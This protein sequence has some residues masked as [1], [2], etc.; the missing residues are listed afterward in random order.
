MPRVSRRQFIRY[1]LTA[2]GVGIAALGLG[3]LLLP[4]GSQG[5]P[6]SQSSTTKT[7][8]VSSY[9]DL[10]D[11]QDFL[12]W[13]SSV[14]GP[15]AGKTLNLTLEE[16]FTPLTLQ[17]I[18]GDFASATGINDLYS[19]KPYSLQLSDVSLMFNTK[20]PTYDAF[21]V[22][23]QNLGA[24]PKDSL[25]PIE[26]AETYP[27]LTYPN[28]DFSD[29]NQ[30]IWDYV[31]TYP[32]ALS[33]GPGGTTSSQVPVLPLDT[34]TMIHYYRTDIYD[35]LELSPPQTWDELFENV[36]VLQKAGI[37]PFAAASQAAP[38]IDIVYEFLNH[39][40]SFG[41]ELWNVDGNVITPNLNDDAVVAALENFVR[42]HDYSDSG[43]TTYSWED[44]FNSLA[45]GV[46]ASAVLWNDFS[47]WLDDPSRSVA[48]GNFGFQR[49]PAGPQGSFSTFGGAGV[50]VSKYSNNPEAAWLWLQ[51]A[52]AK[53]T[54]EAMALDTYHV[55]PTRDSVTSAP[56]VAS[57][58]E[59]LPL[60]VTNLTKEIV[61][62]G[63]LVALIGFP[64]W[65]DALQAL[66][67]NL[68]KAWNGGLSP[69]GALSAAQ[70]QI[71]SLGTLTF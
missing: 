44:V 27:N 12:T 42:F 24:F 70:S 34:P 59:T 31:G 15:Y 29:F 46:S 1:G 14:S 3:E 26:L 55:Y 21:G 50:G 39:V 67:S 6:S 68:N 54:Q 28:F 65:F 17:L 8:S 18:D 7:S 11:Y 37:T 13:L 5:G 69:A 53:G 4:K 43:S 25:S 32:P 36:Q 33:L 71:E 58:L 62:S 51:W 16:E 35:K 38:D 61:Q 2:A 52:T 47:T 60:G 63:G 64:D 49:V 9:S 41:G 22:D 10:P 40:A 19:I 66:A 57:A 56:A 48:A 23:N 20:S 30:Y 45:H